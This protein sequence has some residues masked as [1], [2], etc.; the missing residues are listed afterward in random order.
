MTG[1]ADYLVRAARHL[2]A[3]GLSPGSSSNLSVRIGTRILLTPTGSSLSRVEAADLSEVSLEDGTVRTG[4]PSKEY[5]LHLAMYRQRPDATAVVHLHSPYATAISC[6]PPDE[7]GRA[8]LPPLTP[9]RVMR[10]G[11]VPVAPY[12]A[13][14]SAELAAGVELLAARAAV[15][16]LAQHGSVVSGEGIDAAVDLA[17][18]LETAAQVTLLL[19]GRDPR[20]LPPDELAA[21]R[22]PP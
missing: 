13:P 9:Y 11:D 12:A 19:H 4:R 20:T 18:E 5:P 16:L 10:L 22:P 3:R 6:L 7:Q 17:E 14:G 1:D 15:L 8:A 21:L 2:A